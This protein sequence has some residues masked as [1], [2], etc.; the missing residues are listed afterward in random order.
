MYEAILYVRTE[1]GHSIQFIDSLQTLSIA[2]FARILLAMLLIDAVVS[3]K[4][5]CVHKRNIDAFLLATFNWL[6]ACNNQ[7]PIGGTPRKTANNV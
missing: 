6:T 3:I 7:L 1:E 2:H 4:W 5:G